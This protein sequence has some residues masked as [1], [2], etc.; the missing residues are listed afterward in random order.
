[1]GL[2]F[3]FQCVHP[4]IHPSIHPF[5]HYRLSERLVFLVL[6]VNT[7]DFLATRLPHVHVGTLTIAVD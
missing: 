1:M 7:L 6:L 4:S 3:A 5:I 2:A